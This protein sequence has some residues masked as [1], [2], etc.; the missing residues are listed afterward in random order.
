MSGNLRLSGVKF[1]KS[2]KVGLVG[3]ILRQNKAFDLIFSEKLYSRSLKVK[4]YEKRSN[5]LENSQIIPQNQAL[6]VRCSKKFVSRS[7]KV[8]KGRKSQK[9][10]K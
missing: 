4:N 7:F 5:L 9:K 3:Q 1:R 8:I 6:G 10:V 2:R